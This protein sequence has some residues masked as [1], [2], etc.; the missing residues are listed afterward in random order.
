MQWFAP[1]EIALHNLEIMR[2]ESFQG[3][4]RDPRVESL[5][6]GLTGGWSFLFRQPERELKRFVQLLAM[7]LQPTIRAVMNRMRPK[8]FESQTFSPTLAFIGRVKK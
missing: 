2:E 3:L 1:H 6:S 7:N 4:F 5:W 8:H